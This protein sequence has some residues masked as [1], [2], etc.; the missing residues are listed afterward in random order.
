M[1]GPLDGG[2]KASC[3]FRVLVVAF[4]TLKEDAGHTAGRDEVA[5]SRVRHR[6]PAQGPPFC[7]FLFSCFLLKRYFKYLLLGCVM[8]M[9]V[10]KQL[11]CNRLS[12]PIF[13][14]LVLVLPILWISYFGHCSE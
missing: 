9:A 13:M 8:C 12:L 2:R 10:R 1:A 3:G 14:W 4:H 11:L 6:R 5:G 7:L